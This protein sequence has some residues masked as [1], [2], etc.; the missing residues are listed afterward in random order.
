MLVKRYSD[1]YVHMT[2]DGIEQLDFGLNWSS[3]R[4]H[5]QFIVG[6]ELLDLLFSA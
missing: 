6:F 3:T 5:P 4:V 2:K 1:N